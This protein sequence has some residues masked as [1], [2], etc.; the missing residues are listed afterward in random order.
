MRHRLTIALV[1]AALLAVAIPSAANAAAPRCEA[2][3]G[4]TIARTNKVRVFQRIRGTIDDGQTV[5]V[6]TCKIGSRSVKRLDR[7]NNSLD[8][9][10]RYRSSYLNSNRWF[11]LGLDEQTGTSDAFDLFAYDLDTGERTFRFS[12]D[13]AD[14]PQVAVTRH[15]GIAVLAEGIVRAFDASGPRTLEASGASELSASE[16]LA[17]WT[18]AGTPRSAVLNGHPTSDDFVN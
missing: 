15:G 12:R 4:D 7:F 1:A 10:L 9:F 2:K 11:V 16:N 14:V 13:G 6:Y 3:D 18:V 17:Y 8:G 5:W